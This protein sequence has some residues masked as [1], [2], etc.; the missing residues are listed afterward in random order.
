M[1]REN[2]EVVRAGLRLYAAHD[3][4]GLARIYDPA[5]VLHHLEG[6]PEPGPSVGRDAVIEAWKSNADAWGVGGLIEQDVWT[7]GEWVVLH[8]RFAT[9]GSA[10]GIGVDRPMTGVF[11]IRN[12]LIVEQRSLWGHVDPLEA[13]GLRDG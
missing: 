5:V 1:S 3:W 8:Y 13:V 6:W 11:R 2:V 12:R 10:S 4:E 9:T 7:R